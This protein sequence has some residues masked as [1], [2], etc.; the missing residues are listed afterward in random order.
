MSTLLRGGLIVAGLAGAFAAGYFLKPVRTIRIVAAEPTVTHTAA[1]PPAPPIPVPEVRLP[2][3]PPVH[4]PQV[5]PAVVLG[6][7]QAARPEPA[8]PLDAAGMAMI[9]KEMGIKTTVVDKSEP[10]PAVLEEARR[11]KL[12]EEENSPQVCGPV[13]VLPPPN[14][15]A[16]AQLPLPEPVPMG[17]PMPRLDPPPPPAIPTIQI[18]PQPVPQTIPQ[19]KPVNTRA[20]ALDFELTRL[21]PSKVTSVELWT[22]RDGGTTWAKTDRMEGCV[23]PFRTRLGSDGEYGFRLVCE[24][25]VGLRTPEPRRGD[26]PDLAVVLDTTP[27]R[28]TDLSLSSM[29][30]AKDKVRVRWVMTD[31]HLEYQGVRIEYSTDGQTWHRA[32]IDPTISHDNKVGTSRVWVVPQGLPHRVMLRVTVR[33]KAG[34]EATAELPRAVSID[35]V[36]PVGKLTGVRSAE[37][38]VGPM[39]REVEAASGA[40]RTIPEP[41]RTVLPILLGSP[42]IFPPLRIRL[43]F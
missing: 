12:K 23:S 31:E 26:A 30:P 21:G 29:E 20:I 42:S 22:T 24:S 7:P 8:D 28:I 34:N 19:G 38:D 3:P 41:L 16:V 9:R 43:D 35:L 18:D 4:D 37:L 33:D 17:G 2:D 11:R 39:P 14:K 36:A 27:P 10:L 13:L 32:A 15:E 5:K 1:K 25:E 40:R 6:T